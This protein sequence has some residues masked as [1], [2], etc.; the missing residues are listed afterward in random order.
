MIYI[1]N[2]QLFISLSSLNVYRA[3][4]LDPRENFKQEKISLSESVAR[5][6]T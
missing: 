6:L 4:L 3:Y 1:N 5:Y 2:C